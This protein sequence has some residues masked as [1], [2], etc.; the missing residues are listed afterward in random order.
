VLV[1]SAVSATCF[2]LG[3]RAEDRFNITKFGEPYR[4]YMR[5]VP[6]LNL[7]TGIWKWLRTRG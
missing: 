2:A 1:F 4:T 6:A 7:L 3:V 5:Q